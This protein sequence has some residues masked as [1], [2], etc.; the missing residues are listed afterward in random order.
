MGSVASFNEAYYSAFNANQ[1]DYLA[2]KFASSIGPIFAAVHNA[3]IGDVAVIRDN[4][5]AFRLDQG[6]WIADGLERFNE[7]Y[8]V[9][10]DT[11]NPAY[12][13]ELLDGIISKFNES[14][15]F[16]SFEQFVSQYSYDEI[17]NMK[18]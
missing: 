16:D 2:G 5:Q 14:T 18:E 10:N 4:N 17:K 8:E 15:T 13:K 9:S 11:E 12:N 6:Y 3:V 1:I 7:M